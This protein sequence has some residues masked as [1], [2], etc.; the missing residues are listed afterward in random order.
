ME[1][2]QIPTV[3]IKQ[4]VKEHKIIKQNLLKMFDNSNSENINN[5]DLISKTD[6]LKSQDMNREYINYFVSNITPYI[7]NIGKEVK[8]NDCKIIGMWY[9]QYYKNDKH[10]WH[11]H[12]GVNWANIYYVELPEK[13]VNTQFYDIVNKKI[14]KNM[15]IN[16][17]DLITFPA[18]MIHR[19][20]QNNTNERKSIISFN[21]DFDV[22]L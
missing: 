18:N 17:G 11:N 14:L 13:S 20:P 15:D 12:G 9:Q 3:I 21:C 5:E 22:R 16:E 8:A 19:S 6:W 4:K 2:F 7:K 1:I 10:N